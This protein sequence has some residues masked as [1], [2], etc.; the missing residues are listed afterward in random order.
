MFLKNNKRIEAMLFLYFIAL[1]LVSLI[2]RN[3]RRQM[4]EE[5]IENLPILPAR[6]KTKTPTWNNIR[7]F[8]RNVHLALITKGGKVLQS[9]VKGVTGLHH[10][11]LKL[12]KV[13]FSV[14]E[15]LQD[16]WWNFET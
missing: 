16:G 3:I 10:L 14:Y 1:M 2:E 7:Y 15:N 5:G 13:P 9:T 6:K 8:F 11:L 4:T 12:L